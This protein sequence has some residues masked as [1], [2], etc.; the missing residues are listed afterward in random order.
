MRKVRAF[1]GVR[2]YILGIYVDTE[3][4]KGYRR[5]PPILPAEEYVRLKHSEPKEML[6]MPLLGIGDYI[7]MRNLIAEIKKTEKYKDY[8][9]TL[10]CD[11]YYPFAKYLDSDV[12][13]KL[14]P[15]KV[16]LPANVKDDWRIAEASRQAL[17][18]EGLKPYYDTILFIGHIVNGEKILKMAQHL[19]HH[20]VS[21]ERIEFEY[22]RRKVSTLFFHPCT[23][24]VM[25]Y[26][27]LHAKS[28]FSIWKSYFE[29]FLG[30]SIEL[31]HPVIEPEKIPTQVIRDGRYIVVNPCCSAVCPENMWHR[32]NWVEALQ[33][34]WEKEKMPII[35]AVAKNEVLYAEHL[36]DVLTLEGVSAEVM[37]G[38][39][40]KDLLALLNGAKLYLGLDSGLFHIAA[41]MGKKAVCISS[42]AAFDRWLRDYEI[43]SKQLRIVLPPNWKARYMG[44]M[45]D[46]ERGAFTRPA[47][48]INA[49][50]VEDVEA[51]AH[52]L[53]HKEHP[54]SSL[55]QT[56]STSC[57][58]NSIYQHDL[59][60]TEQSG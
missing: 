2:R 42:G 23:R 29:G 19:V 49:V 43:R 14:L 20:I 12:V 11:V 50:R 22:E 44:Q 35:F 30:R 7:V 34:L 54:C 25:G 41:A 16:L 52:D 56:G 5:T 1:D 36:R 8:R 51:A 48:P 18:K 17:I 31:P 24:V 15:M 39:G 47:F 53:L 60:R 6:I 58:L 45:S 38:L 21:R 32:N 13:D 9:I 4:Y 27:N 26:F 59:P 3:A 37:P 33:W 46:E 55:K 10:I 57:E 28:V 40:L